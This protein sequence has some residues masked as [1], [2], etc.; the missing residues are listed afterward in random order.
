MNAIPSTSSVFQIAVGGIRKA[1][2]NVAADA[3][4]VATTTEV[5][6][7][8]LGALLDAKQ[9]ALYVKAGARMISVSDEMIS[10]LLD[11][12]A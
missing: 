7:D 10:S 1:V 4:V 8:T 3:Q 2:N 11:V 5:T 9:Q 12:K 6:G